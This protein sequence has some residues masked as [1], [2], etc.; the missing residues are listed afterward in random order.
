MSSL[1]ELMFYTVVKYLPPVFVAAVPFKDKLRFSKTV[2]CCMMAVVL[3]AEYLL[4]YLSAKGLTGSR[5]ALWSGSLL[6]LI[7]YVLAV[8]V[9]WGKIIFTL[10]ILSNI[11]N[12]VSIL[13]KWLE[14]T[15][16]GKAN[17]TE[18]Y[19]YVY[20]L[21]TLVVTVL[22]VAPIFVYFRTVYRKG[23]TKTVLNNAWSYLWLIP[24]TFYISWLHH[25]D[26]NGLQLFDIAF[27]TKHA[28]FFLALNSGA[29]FAYHTVIR[30]MNMVDEN[31]HL[32]KSNS[33][34]NQQILQH[35]NLKARIEEARR[36]K[37]DLRHHI[38]VI[39]GYLQNGEYERTR[40]Y[41]KDH[42]KSLPDDSAIVF[43]A[44]GVTNT[45]L[46]YFA[47][48]AK[49][50]DIDF[51]VV[52]ADIPEKINLPDNVF[53]VIWGNLLENAIDACAECKGERVI[54]IRSKATGNA[55]YLRIENTYSGKTIR[56][57]YMGFLSGKKHGS[58]IG[59][60]SV[61]NVA[62]RYDGVFE[63]EE[64]DG[65]FTASVFLN[66]PPEESEN[67]YGDKT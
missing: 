13:S 5:V 9:H 4:V 60:S 20:S 54:S 34:L 63:T 50:N 64:K 59:L 45:L 52:V 26:D 18:I 42:I 10:I 62:E 28:L 11:T 56:D 44:H 23:I 15:V 24:F 35:E 1:A 61:R 12:C 55:F 3:L 6:C 33:A 14:A 67:T 19:N 16:F 21:C 31:L 40:E 37:H 41:L 8:R 51:D 66:V 25:L 57:K 32:E 2:T 48:L 22:V 39:D 43:C 46:L 29:F 27:E 65:R 38:V 36:A 30:M 58:G 49:N 17:A 7:L 47:Q 53:S